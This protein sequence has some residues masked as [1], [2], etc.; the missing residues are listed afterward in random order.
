MLD[1]LGDV[2]GLLEAF[3]SIGY[4]IIY[5]IGSQGLRNFLVNELFYV[6]SD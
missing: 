5:L 3:K 6:K 4:A 1:L 2:G